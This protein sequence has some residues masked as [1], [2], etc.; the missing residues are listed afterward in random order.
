MSHA[1]RASIL[2]SIAGAALLSGCGGDA[3]SS[4]SS[5]GTGAGSATSTA[6][7]RATYGLAQQPSAAT[8]S[9]TPVTTTTATTGT[10]SPGAAAAG[11]SSAGSAGSGSFAGT[12]WTAASFA[13]HG[14]RGFNQ[15]GQFS[16]RDYAD[17]AATGANVVRYFLLLNLDPNGSSYPLDLSGVDAAVQAGAQD[18]FKVVIVFQPVSTRAVPEYWNS[19]A[20][21]ASLIA[22]WNTTAARY[23]GNT[24]IAAYDLINEPT[25][26]GGESQWLTLAGQLISAIRSADSAH[27][28]I[29]EPSPGALPQAFVNFSPI[30]AENIIYSVHFYE[31][32][33]FTNQGLQTSV[34]LAYPSD[35]SSPIGAV[36]KSTLAQYL[37]PVRQFAA[38]YN[39]PVYVG[40]FSAVRWAPGHS[41]YNYVS[42]C[43]ALF[44]SY[45]WSWNYHQWRG[46][47]A[48]DPELP[49]SFFAQFP[50]V[51]A[52]PQGWNGTDFASSRTDSTDT[53]LLLKQYFALNTH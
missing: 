34:A 45:G 6:A 47:P 20:L 24:T 15:P 50:Y 29:F 53:M 35:A 5:A 18:G 7:A 28:I 12:L 39:A 27:P 26:P 8:A 38:T 48:W 19:A 3:A 40:E 51:N 13:S 44:E 31:P 32:Y 4:S 22:D 21:Q 23:N 17:M 1:L 30:S 36:D 14:V 37:A 46:Y 33:A 10:S 49:E 11:A 42:D 52:M 43:I 2:C 25:A 9:A 41:A 16:A